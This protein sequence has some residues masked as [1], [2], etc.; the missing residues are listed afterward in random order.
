MNARELVEQD[1]LS[2]ERV[3]LQLINRIAKL[4]RDRADALAAVALANHIDGEL[5]QHIEAL[6]D[7]AK[8][9]LALEGLDSL[10]DGETGVEVV[11]QQRKGTPTYN[12]PRLL[13]LAG[14]AEALLGA[15]QQLGMVRIDHKALERARAAAPAA[16]LDLIASVQE[17]GQGTTALMFRER[18]RWA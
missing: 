17:P 18:G 6:R 2:Q 16:W 12:V 7:Q 11:L 10:R 8:Q 5:N 14:G 13:G 15:G 4:E 1:A 9:Y 3:A